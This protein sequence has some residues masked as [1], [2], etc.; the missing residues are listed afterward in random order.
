MSVSAFGCL[1]AC[2]STC[3]SPVLMCAHGCAHVCVASVHICA[4]AHNFVME[5]DICNFKFVDSNLQMF[6]LI[7]PNREFMN[8]EKQIVINDTT[9][10]LQHAS[11]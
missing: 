4:F 10:C 7:F 1:C 11:N 6:V 8:Y 9:V 3:M 2:V 5:E